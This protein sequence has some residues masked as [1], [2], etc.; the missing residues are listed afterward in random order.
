MFCCLGRVSIEDL[1]VE[2]VTLLKQ[3]PRADL[4][5]LHQ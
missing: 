5:T 3:S 1:Q 4:G 2:K